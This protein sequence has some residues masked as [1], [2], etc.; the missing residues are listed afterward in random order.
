LIG[1]LLGH[2]NPSTTQRYTHLFQDPQ[3]AAV[4]K[5][6]A[7]YTAASDGDGG[8]EPIPLPTSRG[9]RGH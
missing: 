7:I 3:R 4:E 2:S 8:T 1:S 6:A 5:V 9:R